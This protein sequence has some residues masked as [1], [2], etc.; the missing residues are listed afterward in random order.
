MLA[1]A[2]VYSGS[3]AS[4]WSKQVM[5]SAY[6]RI[7][8]SVYPFSYHT[9]RK[10]RVH[11]KCLIVTGNCI[12][13]PSEIIKDLALVLKCTGIIFVFLEDAVVVGDRFIIPAHTFQAVR[14]FENCPDIHIDH[15]IMYTRIDNTFPKKKRLMAGFQ[16]REETNA[17]KKGYHYNQGSGTCAGCG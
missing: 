6:R 16:V 7:F 13:V 11:C 3:I 2:K 14:F 17:A 15:T 5:A 8:R 9:G 10:V 1:S 12:F 4:A